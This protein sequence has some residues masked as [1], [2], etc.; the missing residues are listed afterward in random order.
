MKFAAD[1]QEWL[2]I[3]NELCSVALFTKM[4]DGFGMF[5]S[6]FSHDFLLVEKKCVSNEGLA[7]L[8]NEALIAS[9]M[10]TVQSF[11]T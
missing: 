10:Q 5:L 6:C 1:N 9:D 11:S 4:R 2:S 8:G 7:T 3:D